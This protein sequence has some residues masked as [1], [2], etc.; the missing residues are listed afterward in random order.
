MQSSVIDYFHATTQKDHITPDT[1]MILGQ[2]N[3]CGVIPYVRIAICVEV[4]M[5]DLR[6]F[7]ARIGHIPPPFVFP[8]Q[9]APLLGSA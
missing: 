5:C 2:G 7:L 1:K 6:L 3:V 9:L 8:M 4:K